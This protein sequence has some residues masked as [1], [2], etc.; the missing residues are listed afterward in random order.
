MLNKWFSILSIT[1]LILFLGTGCDR[2]PP[3]S[4]GGQNPPIRLDRLQQL[5]PSPDQPGPQT[6]RIGVGAILSQ[7]GTAQSYQ[8]LIDTLGRRMGKPSILVQRKTYQELNDLLARNMVDI[9]FICT[10]AYIEELHKNTMSLL[11]VPQI[12][13]ITTYQSFVIVPAA[14]GISRIDELR[15]KTFA[16]TDPLSNTGYHYPLTLLQSMGQQPETFFGRTIFTYSHDRSIAAVMDGIADGASVDS[17]VYE[18]AA[19][20]NS[21]ITNKT[22]IIK[23]SRDFGIPPVVVPTSV[24]PEKRELL[25]QIL[26]SLHLDQEGT[27]ALTELGIDRFVEPDS[28]LYDRHLDEQ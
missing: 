14:S 17:Q 11:V 10:G 24:A 20:R 3:E 13:G 4:P 12:N 5:P 1:A 6:L 22:R 26:L 15:G 25:K 2:E 21:A 7:Q 27:K 16:F 9:G 23:K 28:R 19:K 8:L 18:F